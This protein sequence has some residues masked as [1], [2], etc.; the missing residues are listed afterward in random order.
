MSYVTSVG[1][2]P[3]NPLIYTYSS[4]SI[5]ADIVM[6]WPSNNQNATY[7][8]TDWVDITS[9]AAR[10]VTMPPANEAGTGDETVFFNWGSYTITIND[11]TGGNITTV[12]SGLTKR[13]WITDNSTVAGSWKIANI[14]SGT[15][16]ADASALAGYG[17]VAQAGQLSQSMPPSSINT[18]TTLNAGYRAYLV[19]WTGGSGTVTLPSAVTSG[20]NWFVNVKNGGSGTLTV[21]GGGTNIDGSS[22]VSVAVNEGFTIASN[23]TVYYTIGRLTPNTAGFTLLNKSVTGSTDITL[24]AAE[25]VYSIINYTGT[26]GKSIGV[27]VPSAVNEWVMSNSSTG[28]TFTLQVKTS[29]GTGV[30]LSQGATRILYSNASDVF[31]SDTQ[32]GG[33]TVSSVATGTGLS[34]GPITSTGTISLANTAVTAGTYGASSKS[35]VYT[36]N[37]QGQF[38]SSTD[39]TID[40]SGVT[41]ILP[42]A[43][44]GTSSTTLTLNNV[45]LGNGTSAVQFVSPSGTGNVL[46][47]TGTTWTSSASS[48]KVTTKQ[49]TDSTDIALSNFSTQSNVGSTVSI[50]IPTKGTIFINF[51]GQFISAGS[52]AYVGF[53]LRIGSTNYFPIFTSAGVVKHVIGYNAS[54][55]VTETVAAVGFSV[56]GG[57]GSILG[58]QMVGIQIEQSGIVTGAQTVQVVACKDSTGG[59][60]TI[61]GTVVTT[62]VN[63]IVFDHT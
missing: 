28:S 36:V 23:G 37:A 7:T 57:E 18:S 35:A 40:V 4:I 38:T 49:V 6:V 13:I 45:I 53:G 17:I 26:V 48:S 19:I 33:G 9:D 41:G 22:T 47:A 15:T 8:A 32:G 27:I 62:R 42:V 2:D 12:A 31:F 54:G 43:Q 25:A 21:N 59:T 46:T 63:I 16:N 5:T 60:C 58:G 61:K 10:V 51:S 11:S 20:S 39:I 50:T 34:G 56:E 14:G 30:T 24:S 29:G 52:A 1:G 55:A 3:I 44:G